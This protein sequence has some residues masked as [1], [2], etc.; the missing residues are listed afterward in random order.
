MNEWIIEWMNYWM[1]ETVITRNISTFKYYIDFSM[2]F[3]N[4][5]SSANKKKII[6]F[7]IHSYLFARGLG[8]KFQRLKSVIIELLWNFFK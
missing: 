6:S 5:K 1:T 3:N 2:L 7:L 4:N 8:L